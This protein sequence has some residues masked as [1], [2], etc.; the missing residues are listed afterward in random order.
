MAALGYPRDLFDRGRLNLR[1]DRPDDTAFVI[2]DK[3]LVAD[4]FTP[5]PVE[6]RRTLIPPGGRTV[7]LQTLFGEV[8]DCDSP[9]PVTADLVV[10]FLHGDDPT[11]RTAAIPVGATST[12]DDIRARKCTVRQVVAENEIT[13]A[14]PVVDGETMTVDLVIARRSGTSRLGF[15]SIKGT[16]LF[17]VATAFEPGSPERTLDPDE[18]DAVIPLLV[19]VNRCDSHAVAETTRKFGIDL[20]VSVDGSE[21]Q[22]VPVSI[23]DIEADLEAMLDRCRART[24]Q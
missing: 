19:D 2:L 1:I 15:D 14:N 23:D 21:S 16:V 10:T 5:A 4:H 22:L 9:D 12:L 8:E 3:Q 11:P 18:V 24:G 7:A 6:A 13:L 20:A 17:G